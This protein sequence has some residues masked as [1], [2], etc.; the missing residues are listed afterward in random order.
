[1]LS[2][3]KHSCSITSPL[4][5]SANFDIPEHHIF[6]DGDKEDFF[7]VVA[8]K[9]MKQ[10]FSFLMAFTEWVFTILCSEKNLYTY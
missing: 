4:V 8:K 5:K 10:P 9:A 6:V 7:H 1:M 3:Y 2:I